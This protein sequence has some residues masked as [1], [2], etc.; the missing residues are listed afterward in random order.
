[1]SCG[2]SQYP[3][4][5]S[6]EL[7][8]FKWPELEEGQAEME[9]HLIYEGSLPAAGQGGKKTRAREKH[10]IRK[11]FHK[12]LASLWKT[13]PFLYGFSGGNDKDIR[14]LASR[15]ARCGYNFLP[16]VSEWFMVACSLDIL[17]FRRDG[18]GSLVKSGGDID[19]RIK[20]LFDALRMPQTCDE[21][22]KDV[23]GPDEDPFY[24]LLEDDKLISNVRVDTNWLLVPPAQSEYIHDV[25]L[26]IQVKTVVTGSGTYEAAFH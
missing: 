2:E 9:F 15:Y 12:Q 20:V 22:C 8:Y 14:A 5:I 23:P 11:V 16:L 25:H 21:V 19:N 3:T 1:M 26:I 6:Q 4:S 13:H 17:F 18:P 10:D 24:C 7:S